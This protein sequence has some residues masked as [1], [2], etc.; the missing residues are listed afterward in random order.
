MGVTLEQP[1]KLLVVLECVNDAF[2]ASQIK[3][4]ILKDGLVEL[5]EQLCILNVTFAHPHY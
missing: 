5:K 1:Q 3:V 4:Q 2:N